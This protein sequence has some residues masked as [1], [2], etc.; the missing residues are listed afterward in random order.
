[1]RNNPNQSNEA[2]SEVDIASGATV[3]SPFDR[4]LS[5]TLM[6]KESAQE[7]LRSHLPVE[8]V[9]YLKPETIEQADTSFIDANLKRRFIDRLFKVGLTDDIARELGTE[10]LAELIPVPVS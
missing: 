10:S 5:R 8:F 1:M 6:Q 2:N 7:L 3:Q 9:A 4:L